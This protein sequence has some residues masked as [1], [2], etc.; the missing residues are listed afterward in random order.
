M[1]IPPLVSPREP[2]PTH[3]ICLSP[4]GP[5]RG[6]CDRPP[7]GRA[8][9]G[10]GEGATLRIDARGVRRGHIVALV[11]FDREGPL[12]VGVDRDRHPLGAPLRDLTDED[13]DDAARNVL[14]RGAPTPR[15]KLR[16]RGR[17]EVAVEY[18]T[19]L[20]QVADA[21][22]NVVREGVSLR[23]AT[24]LGREVGDREPTAR[25]DRVHGLGH[26][27]REH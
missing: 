3:P 4:E 12:R 22:L 6:P 18:E 17:D 15:E 2:Q 16:E 26:G 9:S 20:V 1:P 24:P 10:L 14:A 11:P 21:D 19:V 25:L 5:L 27:N 23:A 13:V 7:Q 8:G